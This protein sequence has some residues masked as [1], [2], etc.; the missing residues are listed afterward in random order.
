MIS[1]T[2]GNIY[3]AAVALGSNPAQC[4][5]AFMEAEAYDGPSLIIAYSTC[6]AHGID[7]ETSMGEQKA[8]VQSGHFPLYRFNPGLKAEGKNPL[9][10]DS[11]AP[12][13]K[14]SE[15]ALKENRFRAL[16]KTNPKNFQALLDKGDRLVAAKFS[17]YEKL[18][19]LDPCSTE[20]AGE[21][22]IKTAETPVP[23]K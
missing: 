19:A 4:V 10:L 18:A 23:A 12:T 17:L 7:M 9:K 13:M 15:F 5:K 11:K 16:K 6:I 20:N 21:D 8:A 2:Y 3:V 1:M 22:G 14:F